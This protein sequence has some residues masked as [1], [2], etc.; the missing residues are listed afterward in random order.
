MN[1]NV[2]LKS[3]IRNI[4]IF[5]FVALIFVLGLVIGRSGISINNKE[6]QYKIVGDLKTEYKEVNVNL[7]WEVWQRLEQEYISDDINPQELLYGSIE[8]LV[9][10]LND[11]YTSFLDPD[12]VTDYKQSNSGE[13]QG[14]GATLKQDGIYVVVESPID[15]TPA[16]KSGLK[17]NDVILFVDGEDMVN[18]SVY[19]AVEKIRGEAGT[20]VKVEIFRPSENKEYTFEIVRE[21]I[22]IDNISY[23][24]LGNGYY[25]IKIYKFTESDLQEFINLWDS[26][27]LEIKDKNP[28]GLVIDLKNNPG[29]YV[30]GVEYI[31]SDFIEKGKVIF[32]EESKSGLRV[33]HKVVRD[34]R[35]I[36][37]PI[38]VMVNAGSASASEIFAGAI[39]DYKRGLIIG[40]DTVGKGVEQKLITLSDGSLLQVVFQ[41]WLTPLAKNISREDPISPD[42]I[43][44]DEN[45]ND[46]KALEILQNN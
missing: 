1:N 22:D 43:V 24:D 37:V 34:G 30:S 39:Q 23:K 4:S 5:L 45:L 12:D 29:G 41:R 18:Q 21:K 6:I 31:L 36:N 25:S 2:G 28:K 15:N 46:S 40:Q 19:D 35:L 7:L 42:I 44:E 26:V 32:Y 8:G 11:P 10:S 16:Q 9:N 20:K 27:V 38:I 3:L 17:P 13:Y 33:E 14:I